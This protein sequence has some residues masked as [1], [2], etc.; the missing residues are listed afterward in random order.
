[1]SHWDNKLQRFRTHLSSSNKRH[2]SRNSFSQSEN[3]DRKVSLH[4]LMRDSFNIE[5]SSNMAFCW[6]VIISF[7]TSIL[8]Y[9]IFVSLNLPHEKSERER[10]KDLFGDLIVSQTFGEVENLILE[11]C[12]DEA[13]FDTIPSIRNAFQK[14]K[15][16]L[17]DVT[18]ALYEMNLRTEFFSDW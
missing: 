17:P 2:C 1:M 10:R 18:T 13:P 9:V 5:S 4:F 16:I 11:N 14:L 3:L 8:N 6:K 12:L 15:N 7:K